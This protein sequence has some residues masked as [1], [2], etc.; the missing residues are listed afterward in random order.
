MGNFTAIG[1]V[2]RIGISAVITF[3]IAYIGWRTSA[4]IQAAIGILIFF[5]IFYF[6]NT[7]EKTSDE[8]QQL[9]RFIAS[10]FA[11]FA[12]VTVLFLG[13]IYQSAYNAV[14]PWLIIAVCVILLSKIA[15]LVYGHLKH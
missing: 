6:T 3:I 8:R 15:G 13:I 12:S 2:G 5:Y 11:Y 7:K 14:D 1:D 4:F 9:H 10:R